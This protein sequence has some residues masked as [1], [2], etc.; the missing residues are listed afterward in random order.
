VEAVIL[1]EDSEVLAF[2]EIRPVRTGHCQITPKRHIETF[3]QMPAE[4]AGRVIALG[5]RLARRLKAVYKV[6]RGAFVF[7]GTEIPHAHAHVVPMHDR[8]D[9]TVIP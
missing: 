1:W 3:E 7:T 6:D 5:Q 8:N 4:L 9:I 2:L